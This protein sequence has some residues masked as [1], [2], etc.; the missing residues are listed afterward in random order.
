MHARPTCARLALDEARVLRERDPARAA[1]LAA[2]AAGRAEELGLDWLAGHAHS[3]L[4]GLDAAPAEAPA[5]E[6]P[7]GERRGVRLVRKG[8]AWEVTGSG[9]AFFLKDA[10]GLHHLAR[11]LGAPGKEFHALELAAPQAPAAAPHAAPEPDMAVHAHGQSDTGPLLDPQA[12]REYRQRIADLEAEI[13]EA[14]AFHD[15][16]RSS[17]ARDE[18][19]FLA[20]ELSAAVGLGGRDRRTHADAERARVNV[21]RAVSAVVKQIA[22]HDDWLGHHLRTCVKTGNFC[23]YV[24]G[25]DAPV[26]EI[27]SGT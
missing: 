8:A 17:R 13:E 4:D 14:E 3:L 7:P 18:L 27:D 15:P 16:E 22:V 23:A 6:P 11:L 1:T 21:T 12:K 5:A 2:D 20:R 10:K 19:D 9:A 25:P 26:W 24:P